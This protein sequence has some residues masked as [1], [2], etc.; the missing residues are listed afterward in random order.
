ME[1]EIVT[2]S[3]NLTDSENSTMA[4]TESRKRRQ[5]PP[6]PPPAWTGH[7]GGP[8]GMVGGHVPMAFDQCIA[9][10]ENPA[11]GCTAA[12]V[13]TEATTTLE[14]D[15][16]AVFEELRDMSSASTPRASQMLLATAT[17][18]L[19]MAFLQVEEL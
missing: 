19:A 3:D 10:C 6:G 1:L 11:R 4:D 2:D 15:W 14:I 12:P 9:D 17:V 18:F 8:E 13:V 5:N 7:M 16:D